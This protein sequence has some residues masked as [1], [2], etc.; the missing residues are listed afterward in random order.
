MWKT[1]FWM[2]SPVL[3]K[4]SMHAK[5]VC[6]MFLCKHAEAWA[7][8]L[9]ITVVGAH[10]VTQDICCSLRL[11]LTW[12]EAVGALVSLWDEGIYQTQ[13]SPAYTLFCSSFSLPV[14]NIVCVP[15]TLDLN[16]FQQ[17]LGKDCTFH[18][19]A[20]RPWYTTWISC[21]P[22]FLSHFFLRVYVRHST[23]C[24]RL[25]PLQFFYQG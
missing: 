1:L 2:W 14:K 5:C 4:Q 11:C 19:S 25:T 3:N 12:P 21:P 6:S 24:V 10:S 13:T 9:N 23:T 15:R 22:V 16:L 18:N 8:I 7:L 20:C 17:K